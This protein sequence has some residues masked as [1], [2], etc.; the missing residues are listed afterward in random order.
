MNYKLAYYTQIVVIGYSS[1]HKQLKLKYYIKQNVM[2]GA[3]EVMSTKELE[4]DSDIHNPPQY[5]KIIKFIFVK[6]LDNVM[7]QL[8]N[9]LYNIAIDRLS[10]DLILI[11]PVGI[12]FQQSIAQK[13]SHVIQDSV[14]DSPPVAILLP[15]SLEWNSNSLTYPIGRQHVDY[16]EMTMSTSLRC[17]LYSEKS[18]VVQNDDDDE[19]NIATRRIN[20]SKDYIVSV[21][22]C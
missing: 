10:T 20:V 3:D 4:E 8:D 1:L 9:T 14:E 15:L 19:M 17:S 16:N 5:K 7:G 11:S 13:M 2:K 18:P 12:S 6:I 21:F 22:A